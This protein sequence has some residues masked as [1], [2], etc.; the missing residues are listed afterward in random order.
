MLDGFNR[1]ATMIIV[2]QT[3]Q[4]AFSVQTLTD[5]RSCSPVFL[6]AWAD[7]EFACGNKNHSFVLAD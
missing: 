4:T 5:C 6:F 7:D 2:F 3:A 1:N